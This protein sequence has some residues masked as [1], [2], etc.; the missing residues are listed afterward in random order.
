M[1]FT[2]AKILYNLPI[3]DVLILADENYLKKLV[4]LS[5]EKV[6]LNYYLSLSNNVI[7]DKAEIFL[8]N[9]FYNKL[10]YPFEYINYNK[11]NEVFKKLMDIGFGQFVYYSSFYKYP[12]AVS[13]ILS[14]NEIPIFIPCH[15]VISKH[16]IGGYSPSIEIK[17]ILLRHEG[18]V[19]I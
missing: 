16:S 13:R 19:S 15:R 5:Y 11:L 18:I 4:F 9:Y 8:R 3:G 14:K 17:K 12:R 2:H 10:W 7:L 1:S 6:E